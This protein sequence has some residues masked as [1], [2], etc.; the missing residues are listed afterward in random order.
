VID[1]GKTVSIGASVDLDGT[2]RQTHELLENEPFRSF[3]M[4]VRLVYIQ[5]E[6]ANYGHICNILRARLDADLHAHVDLLRQSYNNFING[7]NH[8]F[9][10]HGA[11]EGETVATREIFEAWLYGD[12]FHQDHHREPVYQ[13]L[14]KFGPTFVFAVNA[15]SL[16][17]A[18]L[19]LDLDDVIADVLSE[20][21]VERIES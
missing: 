4:S 11:L 5:G 1:Q 19:I 7:K 6:P 14:L 10:L 9:Q 2:V 12:S 15:I 16:R 20:P 8:Q 3:A 13:E 17:L 18:G 21:R